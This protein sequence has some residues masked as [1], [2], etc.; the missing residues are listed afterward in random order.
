[1]AHYDLLV[2]GGEVIDPASRRRES[3]DIA[4]AGGRV[5][6]IEPSI[7]DDQ[8]EHVESAEGLLVVPGL[9]DVHA[10]VFDG[11]AVSVPAD[12]FCLDRGTTTVADAGSAGANNFELFRRTTAGNRT[13]TFAWLNLSTIGQ[14][15]NSVGELIAIPYA[16]V[17]AAVATAER[18]PETILGFKARLSTYVVGGTCKPV[19]K[20]LREAADAARLPVM[21]HVGDTGEPLAEIFEQLRPGDVVSHILT[22]RRNGILRADGRIIPEVFEARRR[23]IFLD[24]AMGRS[25]VAFPV[26]AAA[27][28]QDLVPDTMSTDLT[29]NTGKIPYFGL[30]MMVSLLLAFGLGLEQALASVTVRAAQV[31]GHEELGRLEIGGTADATLLK[32]EE[33]E[34]TF[35][36]SDGKTMVANRRLVAVG[37]V[38]DGSYRR[39][40][41]V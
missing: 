5:A 41:S 19:L 13:R 6:A 24:A 26:L 25:H 35:T 22:G 39:I 23:G 16:N 36:D 33:G 10:H 21:V 4:F 18:F 11:L 28:E 34:F 27:V 2:R 17:D 8:A 3:L 1:M 9:I 31:I 14:T 15:D 37:V 7:D 40:P 20:L 12:T 38:R 29:Q 30:P 32:L